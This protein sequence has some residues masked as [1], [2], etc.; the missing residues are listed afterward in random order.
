[1]RKGTAPDANV[2]VTVRDRS[3]GTVIATDW[4][5]WEWNDWKRYSPDGSAPY[6]GAHAFHTAQDVT[7]EFMCIGE[8]EEPK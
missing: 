3:V 1:M 5:I 6:I 2:L 8:I 7:V 4:V